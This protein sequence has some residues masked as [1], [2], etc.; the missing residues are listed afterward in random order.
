MTI[1]SLPQC[2]LILIADDNRQTLGFLR[3]VITRLGMESREATDGKTALSLFAADPQR[4]AAIMLN[5]RMPCLNGIDA[6]IA[7]RDMAPNVPIIITSGF[8]NDE[9]RCLLHFLPL[10]TFLPI[11]FTL[12]EV[13]KL[14][15]PN[16]VLPK[17]Q[18]SAHDTALKHCCAA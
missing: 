11:P 6:A 7:I 8:L 4:Y 17:L 15:V 16:R 18:T 14:L 2:P 10:T 5:Y 3:H 13:Q 9:T 12:N 1:L